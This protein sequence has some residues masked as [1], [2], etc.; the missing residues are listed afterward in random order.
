MSFGYFN[1]NAFIIINFYNY[2]IIYY[3]YIIKLFNIL[4][5][6]TQAIERFIAYLCLALLTTL[7]SSRCKTEKHNN[8]MVKKKKGKSDYKGTEDLNSPK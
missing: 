6:F 5:R 8:I 1:V 4:P 3:I 7:D 2:N